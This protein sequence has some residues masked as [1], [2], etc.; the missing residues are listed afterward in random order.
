MGD[1]LKPAKVHQ[2]HG[3]HLGKVTAE[4]RHERASKLRGKERLKANPHAISRRLR[5]ERGTT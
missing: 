2:D 1:K 3:R 4:A 5:A